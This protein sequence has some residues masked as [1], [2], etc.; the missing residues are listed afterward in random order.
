MKITLYPGCKPSSYTP[1][2]FLLKNYMR[3]DCFLLLCYILFLSFFTGCREAPKDRNIILVSLDTLRPDRLGCYG[4]TLNTS[5]HMDALA[6]KGILFLNTRAQSSWTLPSHMSLFTSLY[7]SFHQVMNLGQCL[8]PRI[9]TMAQVLKQN[10]FKTAAFTEGGNL[11]Q[12]HGFG[13]GFD[14]YGEKSRDIKVTFNQATSWLLSNA[15][16]GKFFLFIHTYENHTPYLRKTL[17]DPN[18]RGRLGETLPVNQQLFDIIYGRFLLTPQEKEYVNDLYDSGVF[19]ADS[20]IGKL[21]NVMEKLD[22]MKTTTLIILSDH[23]ED[24]WDHSISPAHGATLY[25]D[26]LRVPLIIYDKTLPSSL[27]IDAPVQLIDIMPTLLAQ[28]GIPIPPNLQGGNLLPL[29]HSDKGS[30][31]KILFSE[32]TDYGP[33]RVAVIKDDYKYI[34]IP[35]PLEVKRELSLKKLSVLEPGLEEHALFNLKEDP[36]EENNLINKEPEKAQELRTLLE[37]EYLDKSRDLKPTSIAQGFLQEEIKRLKSL[38]YI[39]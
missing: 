12:I 28:N 34:T 33:N 5:P 6:S 21:L 3:W 13:R 29:I 17:A 39:K 7:P 30:I 32:G 23:G 19:Y 24:L 15:K 10:G 26:Q 31:N 35:Q 25:E 18:K 16:E 38:G 1:T 22:L 8:N 37:K 20:Y 4:Y 11:F 9:K 27:K 2:F 14:V 36:S